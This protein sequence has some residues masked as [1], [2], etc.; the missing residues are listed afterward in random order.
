VSLRSSEERN[1]QLIAQLD[2]SQ[3]ARVPAPAQIR[4]RLDA[5]IH[6]V[7][8]TQ[9]F[10]RSGETRQTN[11][12]VTEP[13]ASVTLILNGAGQA[14]HA[15]Y[16]VEITGRDGQTVWN[17][18]GLRRGSDGNYIMTLPS[19]FLKPGEYRIRVLGKTGTS[20][21]EVGQYLI[22]WKTQ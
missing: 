14:K 2:S 13:A 15:V 21:S 4:L 18:E 17:G 1:R 20:Y 16:A 5:S 22:S 19:D 9:F 11:A 6:D 7:F 8:S 3:K 10:Q 12:I